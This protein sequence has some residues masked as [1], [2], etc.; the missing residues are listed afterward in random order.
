MHIYI[1][2]LDVVSLTFTLKTFFVLRL[3]YQNHNLYYKK[4]SYFYINFKLHRL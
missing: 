3:K 4:F 1:K 2:K